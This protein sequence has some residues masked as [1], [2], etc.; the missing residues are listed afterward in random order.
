VLKL[1]AILWGLVL[2]LWGGLHLDLWLLIPGLGLLAI[3]LFFS[4]WDFGTAVGQ[5]EADEGEAAKP[6]GAPDPTR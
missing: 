6:P 2:T 4:G 1:P 3:G 5:P